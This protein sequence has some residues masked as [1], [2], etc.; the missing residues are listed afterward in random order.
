MAKKTLVKRYIINTNEVTYYQG[1]THTYKYISTGAVPSV[2]SDAQHFD[3]KP[4][5]VECLETLLPEEDK[6]GTYTIE[7]CYIFMEAE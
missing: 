3:S 1:G 4:Q 6:F 2:M 5:A 7:E